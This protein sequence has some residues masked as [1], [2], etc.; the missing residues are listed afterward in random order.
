M[1]RVDCCCAH[2]QWI[3]L[4]R[5]TP[6]SH[7]DG[8]TRKD[9]GYGLQGSDP[10]LR[11]KLE[12]CKTPEDVLALAKAE[13]YEVSDDELEAISGGVSWRD[14]GEGLTGCPLFGY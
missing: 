1:I 8:A 6:S 3:K 2:T 10:E 5:G 4:P 14:I 9:G 11:E 12:T 7:A 13:G